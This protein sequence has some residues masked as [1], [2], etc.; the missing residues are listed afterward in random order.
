MMATRV[1]HLLSSTSYS[2]AEHVAIDM[3]RMLSDEEAAVY[4]SPA[5]TIDSI[6]EKKGISHISLTSMSYGEVLKAMLRFRP[7]VIHAHDYRASCIAALLPFKGKIISHIHNNN[8]WA[9]K[10][11]LRTFL[12]T[13]LLWRYFK[14]VVVSQPVIDEFFFHGIFKKKAVVIKNAVDEVDIY[15]RSWEMPYN[16]E[17][18]CDFL[19]LGRLTREK[20]PLRFLHLIAEA[21]KEKGTIKAIVI[22]DGSMREAMSK[23]IHQMDLESNVYMKGFQENPYPYLRYANTLLMT[24]I[25]EGFGLAAL[26]AMLLGCPV[27]ATP[28]GGLQKLVG[29]YDSEAL[30]YTDED[31]LRRMLTSE[32]KDR[33]N[34]ISYARSVNNVEEFKKRWRELHC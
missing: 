18:R 22:G 12:Y 21:K 34:L 9:T 8:V 19:F 16:E 32:R 11:N 2:G 3:I 33:E 10:I 6:L 24:S 7:D 1:M 4:V 15:N 17:L 25:W 30:C 29:A 31:F 27:L 26:E 20:D 13:A 23:Y 28:V 5:G 14:I